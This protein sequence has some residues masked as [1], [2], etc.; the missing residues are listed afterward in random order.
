VVHASD[1]LISWLPTYFDSMF[2]VDF[3]V[4]ANLA[5]Q[6]ETYFYPPAPFDV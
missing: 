4:I 1:V 5:A 6:H 2:S 3:K